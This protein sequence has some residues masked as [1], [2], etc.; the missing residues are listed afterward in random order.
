MNAT[1]GLSGA[2]RRVADHARS[3]VRLELQLAATEI[4]R[5]LADL[6][7]GIGLIATAA[8]LAVFALGFALAAAAAALATELKV[9]QALLVVFGAL[10]I[11]TALL[12]A[13]GAALLRRGSSPVP[14]KALE[15][16]RLTTEALRNGR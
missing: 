10:V 16:A 1:Q 8:L 3:L 14:A 11:V 5:K 6:A 12:A 4:K 7:A 15:E 2:A 13:I 9:W